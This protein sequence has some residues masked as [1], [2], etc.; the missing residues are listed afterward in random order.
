VW[1]NGRANCV[2]GTAE[3]RPPSPGAWSGSSRT[4]LVQYS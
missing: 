2:S 4:I 3:D 1:G